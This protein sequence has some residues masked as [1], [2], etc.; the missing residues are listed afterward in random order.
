MKI[1]KRAGCIGF[2]K[3]KFLFVKNQKKEI[4][5]IKGHIEA[6]ETE[7]TAALREFKEE[8]GYIDIVLPL[9]KINDLIYIQ[10][11]GKQAEKF[12]INVYLARLNSLDRVPKI[13]EDGLKLKNL[14]M[15]KENVNSLITHKNIIPILKKIYSKI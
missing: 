15:N 4:V 11:E 12:I 14:W 2:Y 7:E 5:L 1:Q 8:S 10:G 6:G 13:T 3:D 9:I